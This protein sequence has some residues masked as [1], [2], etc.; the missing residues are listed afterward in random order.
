[1]TA[2]FI[3]GRDEAFD[4]RKPSLAVHKLI[5]RTGSDSFLFDPSLG[6]LPGFVYDFAGWN[7]PGGALPAQGQRLNIN[8]SANN[9][10]FMMLDMVHGGDGRIGFDLP[11]LQG[12]ATIGCVAAPGGSEHQLGAATGSASVTLYRTQ[13][14]AH[15]HGLSGG[16]VTGA[17]E[18]GE[19]FS[20]LQPSLPLRL[21]INVGGPPPQSRT[22]GW[23]QVG[24]AVFLGQVAAYAGRFGLDPDGW[25]EAAGQRLK[26]AANL[27]LFN[28]LKTTYGG[29]GHDSF[30]LPDLRGRAIVGAS[31]EHPLGSVFGSEFTTLTVAQ[32]PAHS[33]VLAPGD[34]KTA[35]AG[36]GQPVNIAQPSLA[37]NYLIATNG[38]FPSP[39]DGGSPPMDDPYIGDIVAFAG[40]FAPPGWAF[41]HGQLMPI[42]TNQ[43]LYA[44]LGQAYG[45]DGH[46]NF[47][48]PDLCGRTPVGTGWIDRTEIRPGERFGADSVR[49]TEANLPMHEHSLPDI[50]PVQAR[51]S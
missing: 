42:Q 11:R 33:H 3:A 12:V 48:L 26:I 50:R 16:G 20:N 23:G 34:S 6:C 43:A 44:V 2:T 40:D 8:D 51:A 38:M 41:A 29:D 49:L 10:L 13:M 4:N 24:N 35:L 15:D 21:L 28:I 31:A 14:P 47:A 30:A 25:V 27:A 46:T 36:A 17:T 37:L 9:R 22:G 18:G 7:V 1:M 39:S 32:L 45:G 5:Y 19:R